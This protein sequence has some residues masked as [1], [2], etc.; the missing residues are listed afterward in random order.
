[1][2]SASGRD[3]RP[4]EIGAAGDRAGDGTGD[5]PNSENRP[6]PVSLSD[7][8]NA[9]NTDNADIRAVIR[10]MSLEQKAAQ[11]FIITPEALTGFKTV[12]Q[13]G[14][15]TRHCREYRWAGLSI[16]PKT[17]KTPTSLKP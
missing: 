7:K 6:D 3:R 14:D 17:C 11:L 1:M 10:Q 13:A 2:D 15:A 16:F 12:T 8:T 9:D 5:P 4:Q